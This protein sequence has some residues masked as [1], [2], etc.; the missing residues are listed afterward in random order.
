MEAFVVQALA[1]PDGQ[2]DGRDAVLRTI[3]LG[4]FDCAARVSLLSGSGEFVAD[5]YLCRSF[6]L[7]QRVVG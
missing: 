7:I 2:Y 3:H 5:S 6:E 4:I 1:H